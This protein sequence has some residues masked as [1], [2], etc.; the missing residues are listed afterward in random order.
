MNAWPLWKVRQVV[1]THTWK[2]CPLSEPRAKRTCQRQLER[3]EN[4]IFLLDTGVSL[5][6][7]AAHTQKIVTYLCIG[8]PYDRIRALAWL[9]NFL[10]SLLLLLLLWCCCCSCYCTRQ[11]LPKGSVFSLRRENFICCHTSLHEA[12]WEFCPTLSVTITSSV[13]S[14][15][16][17]HRIKKLVVTTITSFEK[18][19]RQS[20]LQL[21]Q[22]GM[23]SLWCCYN[24]SSP[25]YQSAISSTAARF[26]PGLVC[27]LRF[28][29]FRRAVNQ[30]S[31]FGFH[32]TFRTPEWT[33]STPKD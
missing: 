17:Q 33:H 15:W 23:T 22:A 6:I 5:F 18:S 25:V 20:V 32:R 4:I 26:L 27:C 13:P 21:E 31:W 16:A 9:W 2:W 19:A 12:I 8:A 11:I 24:I 1:E 28:P 3:K 10:V 29:T 14:W 30:T 7:F